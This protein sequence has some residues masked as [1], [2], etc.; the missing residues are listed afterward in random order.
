L[1]V[2]AYD[3]AQRF[4]GVEEAPG[5]ASNPHVLAMLRLDNSWPANDDV[6]WCSAFVSYIAWLLALPRSKSLAARSWLNVGRPVDLREARAAFDVVILSRGKQ[7]QPGPSVTAGAPGH[8]GFYAGWEPASPAQ[9]L[10]LGGNQSNS[11]SVE[12][13]PV[14]RILGIRRLA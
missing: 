3:V 4:L 1:N 10:V 9:V 8:V 6:A 11:V 12:P 2:T 7:P 13:F 14:S 5:V